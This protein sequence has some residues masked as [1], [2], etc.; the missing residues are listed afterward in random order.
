MRRLGNQSG[1]VSFRS[2]VFCELYYFKVYVILY[3]LFVPR[4]YSTQSSSIG[5][6]NTHDL[7]VTTTERS[8]VID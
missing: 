8:R 7:D 6:H 5:P 3:V 4:S 1:D 2:D